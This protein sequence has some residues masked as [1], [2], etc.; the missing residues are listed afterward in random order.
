MLIIIISS[1]FIFVDFKDVKDSNENK[2]EVDIE[3]L[4]LDHLDEAFNEL[5]QI[6]FTLVSG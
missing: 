5:D 4:T 2:S 1:Y 3:D 6:D